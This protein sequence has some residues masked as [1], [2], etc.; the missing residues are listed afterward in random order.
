V[1]G[2]FLPG[3]PSPSA[4]L[5]GISIQAVQVNDVGNLNFTLNG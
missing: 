2:N 3:F 1:Q 5:N 4:Q